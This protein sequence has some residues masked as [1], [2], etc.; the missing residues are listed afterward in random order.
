M[1]KIVFCTIAIAVIIL[2]VPCKAGTADAEKVTAN[3]EKFKTLP[4]YG[5]EYTAKILPYYGEKVIFK[6]LS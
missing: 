1:K 3:K 5:E 6:E 2:A 4:Y